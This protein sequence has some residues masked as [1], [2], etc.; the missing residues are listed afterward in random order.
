MSENVFRMKNSAISLDYG[1]DGEDALTFPTYLVDELITEDDV[2]LVSGESTAG[3]TFICLYLAYCV[4]TGAPFFGKDTE[5]GAVVYVA[6]EAPGTIRRRQEAIRR[7]MAVPA[8]A[9]EDGVIPV[10]ADDKFPVAVVRQ[11]P[12]L[13]EPAG[14][15]QLIATLQEIDDIMQREFGLPIR[16][17][18]VDTMLVAFQIESWNDAADVTQAMERLKDIHKATDAVVLGV[19]H[20]GKDISK[21][22]QG[23]FAS[24]ANSDVVLSVTVDYVGDDRIRA[25]VLHRHLI[26]TKSRD[27]EQGWQS[28]FKLESVCLGQDARGKKRYSA[29]VEP[30]E[31]GGVKRVQPSRQATKKHNKLLGFKVA[32]DNAMAEHSEETKV[33]GDGKRIKAVQ[34]H[35]VR[36]AFDKRTTTGES[37]KKKSMD[38]KRKAFDRLLADAES[39]G[40]YCT[41]AWNDCEWVWRPMLKGE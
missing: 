14:M 21:G 6:A 36:D 29:Y 32:F 3:K 11:V 9:D 23:S 25:E 35:H 24:K 26:L 28:E 38:A 22:P 5:R 8:E 15:R 13:M 31:G 39:E 40:G 34:R 2:G 10:S 19:A 41:G 18:I 4:A 16:L 12:N 1:L 33:Q 17:V 20:H 27:G 37:D 30:V 7:Q